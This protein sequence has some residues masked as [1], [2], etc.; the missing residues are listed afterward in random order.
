MNN[1]SCW[2]I[3]DIPAFAP[4]KGNQDADVCVVGA[5]IPGLTTAYSVTKLRAE[6]YGAVPRPH[7]AKSFVPGNDGWFAD[8][9]KDTAEMLIQHPEFFQCLDFTAP[10]SPLTHP[11]PQLREL[12]TQSF[13]RICSI[14]CNT[15]QWAHPLNPGMT[16]DETERIKQMNLGHYDR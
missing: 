4:L 13:L 12:A 16:A 10:P 14:P 2:N 7:V 1:P 15:T 9:N 3:D 5:G 11:D 8:E 6:K